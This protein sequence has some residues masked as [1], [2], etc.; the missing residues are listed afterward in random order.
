MPKFGKHT[1]TRFITSD[2]RKQLRLS[3]ETDATRKAL[4]MPPKQPPTPGLNTIA[5]AGD[6]WAG[7]ILVE[8]RDLLG[9][10]HLVGS[11]ARV[12]KGDGL[13]FQPTPLGQSLPS[14]Q[15]DTF[16]AEHQFQVTPPFDTAYGLGPLRQ[17]HGLTI[18]ELR[19]D[20]I[21]VCAPGTFGSTVD[22]RGGVQPI[23]PRDRRLQLQVIDIKLTSQPGPGYLA[24]VVLYSIALSAW[25]DHKRF[26][27]DFV[28][29]AEPAIWP[30]SHEASSLA[31][32]LAR[33]NQTGTQ[34]SIAE[35]ISAIT[36]DLIVAPVPVFASRIRHFFE[37]ELP[38]VLTTDWA[39]LSFHVSTK[40]QG[41]DFLGQDW[42]PN[43]GVDAK[44]CLPTTV[45]T[46]HLSR[47]AFVGRGAS[48]GLKRANVS[49]V[50]QLAALNPTDQVFDTHHTLRGQRSVIAR[51]AQ[52]LGAAGAEGVVE[53]SGG[54]LM[55]RYADLSLY[56]TADFDASSAITSALG[57]SAYWRQPR[58]YG[59]T[60]D[61]ITKSWREVR[62]VDTRSLEAEKRELI[63]FLRHIHDI[64]DYAAANE[65]G[66]VTT[67]QVY[68][69][70]NL[71]Y[72]HLRR[73]IGRHLSS[74]LDDR[75]GLAYLAWL[76]PP[77]EVVEN[78]RQVA[79]SVITLVSDTVRSVLALDVPHNYSLLN[80]ARR[81]H[82]ADLPE[83][84]AQFRMPSLF[85]NFLSDQIPSE[86]INDVWTRSAR[87]NT[88]FTNMKW[89]V[90]TR[91]RALEEVTR[92][93][94]TDLK[95]QLHRRAPRRTSLQPPQLV[96]RLT[97]DE[98]L[99]LAF[100]RL[101]AAAQGHENSR[102]R[103]MPPH[104]RAARFHS[105]RLTHRLEGSE[106]VDALRQLGLPDR[107]EHDV[108]H[109][110]DD[111][112]N[113]NLKDGAFMLAAIP[114]DHTEMLD[115]NVRKLVDRD[116][117]GPYGDSLRLS[118]E[119][120]LGVTLKRFDRDKKL[121]VLNWSPRHTLVR[122]RLVADDYLDL[123]HNIS[124]EPVVK[125]YLSSKLAS[126]LHE[127][128]K[129][130]KAAAAES[131]RAA[132]A[133]GS[134]TGRRLKAMPATPI[135]DVLWDAAS[136]AE[137]P[138]GHQP[139]HGKPELEEVECFLNDSQWAAY[140]H[141]LGH[142]LSL[143]WGPPGTGK[144]RTLKNIV[145]GALL[146]S[147]QAGSSLRV[148]VTAA[149][150]AA[151]Q[152]V[153]DPVGQLAQALVPEA[154]VWLGRGSGSARDAAQAPVLDCI[155]DTWAPGQD[156]D[157]LTNRLTGVPGQPQLTVVGSTTQQIHKFAK[158]ASS[159]V[160]ELFDLIV[161]DEA[162]QMDVANAILPLATLA[163]GGR[164]I[165]AGDPLQLPPIHQIPPPVGI[166]GMVGSIYDYLHTYQGV[167]YKA[168]TTNYRSNTEIVDIGKDA[169][170]PPG[171]T[172]HS[173][174]LRL[175]LLYPLPSGTTPPA[176]WPAHLPWTEDLPK[177]LDPSKPVTCIVYPD[178][179]SGQANDFEA[180]TVAALVWL[181]NGRVADQLSGLQGL[182]GSHR[183]NSVTP[184][185]VEGLLNQGV[186]VVTPHRAQQSRVVSAIQQAM[187]SAE[188]LLIRAAVDT[189]ERFQG[190]ERD[191]MIASYAVG[192]P[193]T[194]AEED[195]FLQSLN[196]FN[197]MASRARGKL[198]VFASEELVQHLS[199]D[200]EVLQ[201]S[202]LIKAFA[203]I[204]CNNR[205]PV[206]LGEVVAGFTRPVPAS[207]RWV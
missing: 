167:D 160:G 135:E 49:R 64:L 139:E 23:G 45:R 32:L 71:T 109:V 44:H 52:V 99:W 19:P 100:T 162:S 173:P 143:I 140:D 193:D 170:Y 110:R 128:G 4:G 188:P 58:P 41:C 2:C 202:R 122:D 163:S 157:A 206:T 91:L 104:E 54:A 129:T 112:L 168:L 95:P 149:T 154:Q 73:I 75:N 164:V 111:S 48:E 144:S 117:Y 93:L 189:V 205:Q 72:K 5:E 148:L 40:C 13:A 37:K 27:H 78:H 66:Q 118:L 47:I 33:C 116:S 184:H 156:M 172:A 137:T 190:Q 94:R 57:V 182:D 105:A 68:I 185:T 134:R 84:P 132:L 46:D 24:E 196:R 165:V 175:N 70:D 56:I 62:V 7:S 16:L 39:G 81:Y 133:V 65:I 29:V 14:A 186:G 77:E 200:I 136:M 152:N 177:L 161:I 63:Y 79:E 21:R 106:R 25:L 92:Q 85:E 17:N 183:A 101:N 80:T 171:L 69:W 192:D 131:A 203:E 187:P 119:D 151:V 30:G 51:R 8:L 74:I 204:R 115:W 97:S 6:A 43:S 20:L 96:S 145:L 125:D 12:T 90:E 141:A 35:R 53:R 174:S 50:A 86:R 126:T 76:F 194:I 22:G 114:E 108:Y 146:E 120:V 124:V 38:E 60:G 83:Q 179:V 18:D 178:G 159:P 3:L 123:T 181:L 55:P 166:E 9:P 150:Y 107:D 59:A 82:R 11:G 121:M 199:H 147:R 10:A 127:I 26:N 42:G 15:V 197:V 1:L 88:T 169:T 138:F 89:A 103:V 98:L 191:V 198:I 36:E 67:V 201:G 153:L 176:G 155:I 102:K 28:V 31:Q 34:P 113:A 195:E 158:A 180:Q 207:L 87:W 142:R 130:P 61:P